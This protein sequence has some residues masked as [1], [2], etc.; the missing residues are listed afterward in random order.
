MIKYVRAVLVSGLLA[1]SLV[2]C[3]GGNTGSTG[4]TLSGTAATGKPISNGD[5]LLKDSA[6]TIKSTKTDVSGKFSFDVSGLTPPFLLKTS[7][8]GTDLYSIATQAGTVTIHQISDLIVRN[9]FKTKGTDLAAQFVG[10]VPL[11]NLKASEISDIELT[12]RRTIAKQLKEQN[13]DDN[14]FNLLVTPF[15]A[16]STKFDA[17]LDVLKVQVDDVRGEIRI[18]LVD[19]NNPGSEGPSIGVFSDIMSLLANPLKD[20]QAEI[21]LTLKSWKDTVN[22]K[23]TNTT[24]DDLLLLYKDTYLNLGMTATED[25]SAILAPEIHP[26]K[27]EIFEVKDIV[28]V[29]SGKKIVTVT[30]SAN[31]EN[32]IN[33]TLLPMIFIFDADKKQWLFYG[34]QRIAGIT[35]KMFAGGAL[36][37]SVYDSK[38]LLNSVTAFGPWTVGTKALDRNVTA[39]KKFFLS[40]PKPD[41]LGGFMT[42]LLAMEGGISLDLSVYTFTLTTKKGETVTYRV[43]AQ[44]GDGLL[45][46]HGH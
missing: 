8:G 4:A 13:V 40:L 35:V 3:G 38:D 31:S 24:P 20:A 29:D 26:G 17:V 23:G 5:V 42:K 22:A 43:A 1:L 15:D 44:A 19:P 21:N 10:K 37:L 32:W 7:A 39:P 30:I 6:G 27:I 14:V 41:P 46:P 34:D 2:A 28:A 11:V 25:I 16:N 45:D 9:Y 36:E 33:K 12:I 18:V